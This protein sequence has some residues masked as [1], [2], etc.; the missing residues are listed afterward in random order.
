MENLDKNFNQNISQS[1]G[2]KISSFHQPGYTDNFLSVIN[3]SDIKFSKYLSYVET[4]NNYTE[5]RIT[6]MQEYEKQLKISISELEKQRAI[7]KKDIKVLKKYTSFIFKL[8]L[9][10]S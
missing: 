6:T 8:K 7:L 10:F 2:L 3:N 9:M 5:Q 4:I 1:D